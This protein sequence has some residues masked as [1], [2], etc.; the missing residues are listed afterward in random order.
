M[1]LD[2]DDAVNCCGSGDVSTDSP[3]VP[4]PDETEAKRFKASTYD[5][6]WMEELQADAH[7]KPMSWTSPQLSSTW[8]DD[9][10]IEIC[11]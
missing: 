4:H 3:P 7:L 1:D 11:C 8:I 10:V 5:L 9:D 6:K 2:E